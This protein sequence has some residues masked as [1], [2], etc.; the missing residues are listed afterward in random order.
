MH[1]IILAGGEGIRLRP[2]TEHKPKPMVEIGGIPILEHQ[3]RQLK[4]G[5]IKDIVICESYLPDEIQ[6]YFGDGSKFGVNIRH[7]MLAKELG[8]A[9][10]IR[11]GFAVIPEE[12]NVLVLYGDIISNID[13]AELSR[14]HQAKNAL[15]T[16]V[17]TKFNSPYGEWEEDE[18]GRVSS[19]REKPLKNTNTGVMV[20]NRGIVDFIS[21]GRDFFRGVVEP[22]AR[23]GGNVFQ[24]Y[25]HE[26]FW[27]DIADIRN[28]TEAENARSEWEITPRES[29][30]HSSTIEGK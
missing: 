9:G 3:I 20:L 10:A 29:E 5:G 19:F 24:T 1:A 23:E 8:S 11:E 15:V 30:G 18:R 26:G 7:L 4:R 28:L 14:Q 16:A 2:L 27:R 17:T 13:I 21:D 25:K 6:T 22:I 12:N